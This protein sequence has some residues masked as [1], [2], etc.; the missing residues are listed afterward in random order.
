MNW[1]P[2]YGN[3]FEKKSHNTEKTEREDPLG[4]FQNPFCSKTSKKLNGGPFGKKIRKKS[5]NAQRKTKMGDPL[6][7]PCNVCYAEKGKTFLV[8]FPGPT[9]EI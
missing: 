5:L 2:F 7:S 6:V 8:Q 4:V 9:G 1:G 3:F